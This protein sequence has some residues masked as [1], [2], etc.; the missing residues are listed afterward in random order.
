MSAPVS[1]DKF[2][3][4]RAWASRQ[5]RKPVQLTAYAVLE[6]GTTT[7]LT[8]LDL[9]YEGCRV[10]PATELEPGTRIK[11]SVLRRG[12]IDAEVRWAKDGLAGLVFDAPSTPQAKRHWPRKSERVAVSADVTMRRPGQPN[13]R[14]GVLDAS[15]HGCKVEF[16]DRPG[17]GERMWIKFEGLE[18]L[19]GEVA[20]VE[21]HVTGL[22]FAKTIHPA[23]FDLLVERLG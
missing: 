5:D 15:P 17:V 3:A 22:R 23:V 6:D 21:G 18:A 4:A 8:L 20:W 11:L 19:E 13:Y 10:R 16:V 2:V 12:G 1:P 7:D 14:V 9:S